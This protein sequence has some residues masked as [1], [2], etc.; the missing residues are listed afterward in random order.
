M[1]RMKD[2]QICELTKSQCIQNAFD[3]L[4]VTPCGCLDPCVDIKY[5]IKFEKSG[6]FDYLA[7]GNIYTIMKR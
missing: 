2:T 6:D 7:H 3:D 5:S 1:P 4:D